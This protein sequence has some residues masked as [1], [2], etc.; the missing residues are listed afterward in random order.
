MEMD[1]LEELVRHE[2]FAEILA[3]MTQEELVIAALRLEGLTDTQIGWLLGVDRS[4]I[5]ACMTA[6]QERISEQVP[7]A[8]HWVLGRQL[9]RG[10]RASM[11]RPLE[12]GWLC[13]WH[14]Q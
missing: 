10:P 6:A 11:D 8:A 14:L 7:D 2:T 1:P 12:R 9:P 3:V 5:S 13:R 4:V